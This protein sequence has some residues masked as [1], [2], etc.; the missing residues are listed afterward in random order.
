MAFHGDYAREVVETRGEVPWWDPFRTLPQALPVQWPPTV[1]RTA[2]ADL[3]LLPLGLLGLPWAVRRRPARGCSSSAS[4]R[5]GGPS[6][7]SWSCRPS[8]GTS[9]RQRVALQV[10]LNLQTWNLPTARFRKFVPALSGVFLPIN[11]HEYRH[12]CAA[13]TMDLSLLSAYLPVDRR[14]ALASGRPIPRQTT[15]AALFVDI[16]SFPHR[17]AG[18][19]AGASTGGGG[20]D[21]LAERHLYGVDLLCA[22]V[23]GQCG[24]LSAMASPA[25]LAMTRGNGRWPVA[26]PCRRRCVPLPPSI[27]PVGERSPFRSGS[28]WLRAPPGGSWWATPRCNG[29]TSWS[30][31]LWMRWPVPKGPPGMSQPG[32]AGV[33]PPPGQTPPMRARRALQVR[34]GHD[35]PG[36][37]TSIWVGLAP[38]LS[39]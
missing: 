19:C 35:E 16:A 11:R 2:L 20:T 32:V 36:T 23:S 33:L 1:F 29:W 37:G 12:E 22:S 4:G 15:G 3:V 5:S 25:G 28:A 21:L 13:C 6:T 24:G 27:S 31:P 38:V 8:V 34:R 7:C 17:S 26:W 39:C 9:C 10:R 18:G 30:A 14:Q